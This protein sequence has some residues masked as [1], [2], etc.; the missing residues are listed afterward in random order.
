[1]L[2][3]NVRGAGLKLQ[4]VFLHTSRHTHKA[5][6]G[7]EVVPGERRIKKVRLMGN[8][9]VKEPQALCPAFT[10]HKPKRKCKPAHP[11]RKDKKVRLPGPYGLCR[12]YPGERIQRIQGGI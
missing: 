6:A 7:L 2:H 12:T 4:K 11:V 8:H 3:Y 1:M 10:G 9:I 5:A